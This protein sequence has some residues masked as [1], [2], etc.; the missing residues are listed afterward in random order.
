MDFLVCLNGSIYLKSVPLSAQSSGVLDQRVY[1]DS[2]LDLG[3]PLP[4]PVWRL[5]S[6]LSLSAECL[7]L[8]C[9]VW[10]PVTPPAHSA[11]P[12]AR[13]SA[14]PHPPARAPFLSMAS[15]QFT[16]PSAGP[17]ATHI[18]SSA[19]PHSS[20]PSTAPAAPFVF[21]ASAATPR[22][23]PADPADQKRPAESERL[24]K[25]LADLRLT[26]GH[27]AVLHELKNQREK[28][29]NALQWQHY[30]PFL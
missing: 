20:N 12:P 7:L 16:A 13:H 15:F 26:K 21:G 18:S 2:S 5:S 24:D 29:Q 22:T 14:R 17:A 25:L 28:F 23:L 11:C 4:V 19:L 10:P 9:V 3:H 27:E 30:L 6:S 1:S 8:L